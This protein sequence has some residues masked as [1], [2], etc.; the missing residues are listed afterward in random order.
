MNSAS[1][2]TRFRQSIITR[3]AFALSSCFSIVAYFIAAASVVVV[4][5]ISIS[6][7]SIVAGGSQECA[8]D[9][10]AEIFVKGYERLR[11][12]AHQPMEQEKG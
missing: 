3:I 11:H 9:L 10:R 4:V 6:H 2:F 8:G 5:M 12:S 7:P 1:C